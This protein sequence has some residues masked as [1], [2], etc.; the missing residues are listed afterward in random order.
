VLVYIA[1]LWNSKADEI[2]AR[3]PDGFFRLR[4]GASPTARGGTLYFTPSRPKTTWQHWSHSVETLLFCSVLERKLA[5]A[6]RAEADAMAEPAELY[7]MLLEPPRNANEQAEIYDWM[8]DALLI[9]LV[10]EKLIEREA[11]GRQSRWDRK[12]RKTKIGMALKREAF[13]RHVLATLKENQLQQA[14]R[15]FY[16]EEWARHDEMMRQIRLDPGAKD[17]AVRPFVPMDLKTNLRHPQDPGL[18]DS[19][20]QIRGRS[21]AE[22]SNPATMG[23]VCYLI[24]E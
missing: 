20:K 15:Q 23:R 3:F 5:N 22:L 8:V 14:K 4:L 1:E 10:P 11:S 16:R 18:A 12:L 21:G 24:I 2:A 13:M 9:S 7:H 19:G 6:I 17:V